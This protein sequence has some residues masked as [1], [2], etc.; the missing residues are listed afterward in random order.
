[1]KLKI[2][3]TILE[4]KENNLKNFFKLNKKLWKKMMIKILQI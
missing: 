3:L 1:M 4:K 2:S